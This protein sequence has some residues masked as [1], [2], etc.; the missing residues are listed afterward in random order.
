MPTGEQV[1]EEL[2]LVEDRLWMLTASTGLSVYEFPFARFFSCRYPWQRPEIVDAVARVGAFENYSKR[3]EELLA[4]GIRLINAPE[5]HLRATQLPR[6]YTFL[7]N[8]TPRSVW[9]DQPPTPAQ[10]EEHLAWPI[11]VKG[12]RQTSRHQRSLSIIQNPDAFASAMDVYRRDP[13]LAWQGIVCR[14]YVPLRVVDDPLP[15]RIPS[16][17][18]F[19][20]FWWKGRL[21]GYGR[22]WWE[23]K[24]YRMTDDEQA[25]G[26]AV[27]EEAA[28]R[29]A[30]PFLV[31][32]I[33]MTAAGRWIVIECNDAQESGYAGASP[34]GIWQKIIEL[35]RRHPAA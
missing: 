6:W 16:S 15:D 12:V 10:I 14:E 21:A 32:D 3:Y 35:E 25:S 18:E 8:L 7:E 30:V 22:Y 20:T 27:A 34:I 24:S 2:L 5:E 1:D 13:I 23:G 28:K 26:L 31:V 11:F 17:F 33:A 19:R 9:F 4:G 29:V